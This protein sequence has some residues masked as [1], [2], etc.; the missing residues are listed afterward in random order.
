MTFAHAA[1]STTAADIPGP[2][3]LDFERPLEYR[4]N[5]PGEIKGRTICLRCAQTVVGLWQDGSGEGVSQEQ[6]G[7]VR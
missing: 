2:P 5:W 6:G 4:D 7:C 1:S 3:C